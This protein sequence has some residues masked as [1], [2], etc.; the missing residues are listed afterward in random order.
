M[1][2]VEERAQL[3]Q[4]FL[5]IRCDIFVSPHFWLDLLTEPVHRGLGEVGGQCLAVDLHLEVFVEEDLEEVVGELHL[6]SLFFHDTLVSQE[7]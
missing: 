5:E 6:S 2:S 1:T 3:V 4:E 7:G